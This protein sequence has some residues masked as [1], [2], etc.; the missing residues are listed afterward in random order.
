MKRHSILIYSFFILSIAFSGC[1]KFLEQP[2]YNRI[3]LDDIFKDFEG[4][5]TTLVGCYDNLKSTSY[6]L[7][8]FYIYPELTGGNI[9][10]SR[11]ANLVLN[12]SYNFTNDPFLNDLSDFYQGAY[13]IIF[14]TNNIITNID[15]AQ[16]ATVLQKNRLLADAYTIRALVHFDLMRVFAQPYNFSANGAHEGIILKQVNTNV[17]VPREDP[18]SSKAGFDLIVSDL[19]SAIDLYSRSIAIYPVGNDKT[20]LSQDAAKALLSRV[21]LYREDWTRTITLSSELIALN[22]YPLLS[23]SQYVAS[24]SGKTTSAESIFELAYGNRTGGSLGDYY[25]PTNAQYSQ[26]ATSN[27]LLNLYA[28]GDIRGPATM[29][30]Q[31]T[32]NSI[33]LNFTRKYQG[34]NDSANNIKI[35]RMSEIYLNRAEA[36]AET[37]NLT[38]ALADLNTIRKRADPAIANFVS[39]DKQVV[40]NEIFNERRRELAFEGHTFFD[41]ARKK[42]NLVRTDCTGINCSFNYPNTKFATPKPINQ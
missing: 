29:F 8:D 18:K 32:V 30:R 2:P 12:Q 37:N 23:N 15:R 5:R 11:S 26:L 21:L 9:K 40:L 10:Y 19:D 17:L 42:R 24:W 33:I 34:M 16:D 28:A 27:D 3:S 22:K 41:L 35:I 4:A 36:Y 25:N 20:W 38:A 39:V 6:Y 14:N 7:R 13:N 31:A 1:K